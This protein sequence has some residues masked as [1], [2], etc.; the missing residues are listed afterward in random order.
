MI[1]RKVLRVSWMI[2]L[3]A[4]TLPSFAN[5]I[6]PDS[7]LNTSKVDDPRAQELITRLKEIKE[8]KKSELTKA[9]KKSLRKEVKGIKKEMKAIHGGIYL[10]LAA[11]L[12]IILL[13]IL[14][15]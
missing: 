10:S 7:T 3:M 5:S 4:I 9:E 2:L 1:E 15:L 11:I 6:I 8:I 12:L 14:L 13:L